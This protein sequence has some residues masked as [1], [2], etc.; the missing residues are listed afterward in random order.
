MENQSSIEQETQVSKL[1]LN[2]LDQFTGTEYYHK[3]F[4]INLTDGCLFVAKKGRA[5]WIFDLIASYQFEQKVRKEPF[6]VW[7]FKKEGIGGIITC[8][9]G[10]GN[11]VA[12]QVIEYT[13]FPLDEIKF[14]VTSQVCMLTSEH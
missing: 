2:E 13:D 12:S 1:T 10:N 4:G 14:F 7:Y 11:I 5:Y 3:Y 6:Q 9:D 8:D